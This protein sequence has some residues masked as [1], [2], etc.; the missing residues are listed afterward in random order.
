MNPSEGDI[1]NARQAVQ[2]VDELPDQIGADLDNRAA[3]R[4]WD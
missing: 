2:Q 3:R 1:Q 4:S